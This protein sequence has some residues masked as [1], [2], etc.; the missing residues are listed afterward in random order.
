MLGLGFSI[1]SVAALSQ[2]VRDAPPGY[3]AIAIGSPGS[4][5]VLR[6]GSLASRRTVVIPQG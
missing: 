3:R 4:Y 2:G 1:P 6:L 5:R